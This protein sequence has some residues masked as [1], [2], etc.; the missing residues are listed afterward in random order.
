VASS[1]FG[2]VGFQVLKVVPDVR[3]YR[4]KKQEAEYG[5]DRRRCSVIRKKKRE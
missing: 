5:V 2:V 4:K 3:H 1:F